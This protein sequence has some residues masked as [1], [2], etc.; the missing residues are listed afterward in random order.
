MNAE[1]SSRK[2]RSIKRKLTDTKVRKAPARGARY[3]LR[4]GG[5]LSLW[6]YPTGK[7]SWVYTYTLAEADGS[8]RKKRI[9]LGEYP[10]VTLEQARERHMEARDLVA[11]G[12]DPQAEREHRKREEA[13]RRAAEA[14]EKQKITVANLAA[15]YLELHAKRKKRSWKEDERIIKREVLPVWGELDPNEITRVDVNALLDRIVNRGA[16]VMANRVR[17]LLSKMFRWALGRGYVENNPVEGTELPAPERPKDRALSPD[18]VR[19]FWHG[20]DRTALSCEVKTALRLT[21]VTA[22]RPGEVAGMRY[23]ELSREDGMVVWTIPG[24]RRKKNDKHRVPLPPLALDLIGPWEG[25]TGPVFPAPKDPSK[26]IT[27]EALARA[28][29]RNLGQPETVPPQKHGKR[30]RE[31]IPV[32]PFTPH[33]LRRTAATLM[34]KAGV[35]MVFVP[36]VL[37]HKPRDV[38]R[39]VYDLNEY[40]PE[41]ARALLLWARYLERVIRGEEPGAEVIRFPGADK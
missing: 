14:R 36:L 15:L 23:E 28:L 13:A 6:V 31:K 37:G 10:A 41:K 24:E 7:K 38:T 12:K 26:S 11:R 16:P 1:P 25:R 35:M 9:N 3:E 40:L 27:P 18:E 34:G 8:K 29:A 39:R 22:Q 2:L 33:D 5:G 17:A 19:I 32:A 30:Q 21:L 4:D 20:L